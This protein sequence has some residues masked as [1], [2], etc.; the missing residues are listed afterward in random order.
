MAVTA[1]CPSS[2]E[3]CYMFSRNT[4]QP[5]DTP[6]HTEGR[7]R[8]ACVDNY[9]RDFVNP[10]GLACRPCTSHDVLVSMAWATIAISFEIQKL[11]AH[12]NFLLTNDL[13][14]YR[15]GGC[16]RGLHLQPGQLACRGVS[17]QQ[18]V[19]CQ[20]SCLTNQHNNQQ[21]P[22]QQLCSFTPAQSSPL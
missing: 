22:Q 9:A 7:L 6:E 1:D 19:T 4:R 13:I 18:A 10:A 16:S 12:A 15:N 5:V 11:A 2:K 20:C 21:Q 8:S 14:A 3:C 17:S